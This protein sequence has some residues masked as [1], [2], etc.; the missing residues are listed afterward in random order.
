[1]HRAVALTTLAGEAEIERI[2]N[3]VAFP[4]AIQ[5]VS[6][7]HFEEEASAAARAVLLFACGA[8]ARAH[9]AALMPS[10]EA[11]ANTAE[12]R[13]GEIPAVIGEAEMRRRVPRLVVDSEPQVFIDSVGIHHLAGVH[14]PLRIPN[15]LE[16]AERL[17]EIITEHDRQQ[18]G[19][20]LAVAMLAGAGTAVL[21]HQFGALF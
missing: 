18:F 21:D 12:G 4:A 14:A 9:G 19:A 11:D 3:S 17:N 6:L 1:M 10:A 20:R 8:I 7:Q 5:G 16:L 15:R 2:S 13:V